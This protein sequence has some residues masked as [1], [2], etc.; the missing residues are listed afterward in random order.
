MIPSIEV[1][2]APFLPLGTRMEFKRELSRVDLYLAELEKIVPQLKKLRACEVVL[3]RDYSKDTIDFVVGLREI[4]LA[5]LFSSIRNLPLRS[6][7]NAFEIEVAEV[8]RA[9]AN[10]PPLI[11]SSLSAGVTAIT[12]RELVDSDDPAATIR[13]LLLRRHGLHVLSGYSRPPDTSTYPLFAQGVPATISACID[14]IHKRRVKLTQTCLVSDAPATLE[15]VELPRSLWLTNINAESSEGDVLLLFKHCQSGK[16][17]ELEVVL[18]FDLAGGQA[19][20]AEF[21]RIIDFANSN[22]H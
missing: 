12:A 16:A 2:R 7:G 14:S 22:G 17:I 3:W 21:R 5:D 13:Q 10:L 18:T 6:G 8:Q 1:F 15:G 11:A 4:R 19:H 20:S 9:I